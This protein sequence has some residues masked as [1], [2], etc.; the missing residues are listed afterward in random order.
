MKVSEELAVYRDWGYLRCPLPKAARIWKDWWS[1]LWQLR[2]RELGIMDLHKVT[3]LIAPA[4]QIPNKFVLMETAPQE[5]L[6]FLGN[7]R[8]DNNAVST[9]PYLSQLIDCDSIT[10]TFS[11][12][13]TVAGKKL[14]ALGF[15]FYQPGVNPP[16]NLRRAVGLQCDMGRW[17]FSEYGKPL[18]FEDTARYKAKRKQDRVDEAM[19]VNYFGNVGIDLTSQQFHAG[20]AFMVTCGKPLD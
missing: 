9:V 11:P 12:F 7:S 19:L 6:V 16:S 15:S 4:I 5:W 10:M 18:D 3:D 8:S 13:E 17:D 1:D 2:G 14:G 20:R